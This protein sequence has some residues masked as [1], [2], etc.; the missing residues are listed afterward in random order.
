[1]SQLVYD[2][3]IAIDASPEKVFE[4]VSDFTKHGEWT[5]DLHIEAVS[6]GPIAVGS[7]YKSVG[8][9]M[10]KQLAN[11]VIITE[12]DAPN[13][14]AFTATDDKDFPF[15]QDL[16]F[17]ADGEGTLLRRTVTF[18]MNPVMAI[19][20]KTLIGPLVSNPSMNKKLG[21]LKAKLEA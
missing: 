8:E 19:A 11:K 18:E 9:L 15:H 3:K 16:K 12:F 4:Y 6:D 5:N 20:F 7:E 14:I 1:M 17:E 13:R 21:N 10:G 2:Y